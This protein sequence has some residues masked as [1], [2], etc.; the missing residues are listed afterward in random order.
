MK[1]LHRLQ[2]LQDT[3]VESFQPTLVSVWVNGL[4][5]SSLTASMM[6]ALTVMLAK[7][8]GRWVISKKEAETIFY[9]PEYPRRRYR[10][11][12]HIYLHSILERELIYLTNIAS[13]FV[14]IAVFLFFAG[15]AILLFTTQKSIGTSFLVIMSIMGTFIFSVASH[16]VYAYYAWHA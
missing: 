10:E 12:Q 3:Q 6:G 8:L 5:F 9:C 11:I 2:L 14:H 13:I 15:L 4:W 16:Y 7:S 1:I